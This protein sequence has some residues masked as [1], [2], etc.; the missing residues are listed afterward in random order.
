MPRRPRQRADAARRLP[1]QRAAQAARAAPA[2]PR[3]HPGARQRAGRGRASR[4]TRSRRST[5]PRST[6]TR[7]A[8]RTSL[9]RP[10]GPRRSGSTSSATW[11]RPAGGRSGSPRA[12]ASRSPPARRCRSAP[13]WWCPVHWTDQGMAAVEIYHAPKRGSRR[14]PGRRRAAG[15]PRAGAGRRVRDPGDGRGASPRPASG[16]SWSG[17][18]PGSW[19]W[20][21]AT[22]WSTSAGPA[23]PARWS[24]PTRTRSPPPPS[25]PARYA[26]RIG[27][28]DDDPEGLRG[29]LEDQTLRAD[30]IITTGGTGTGPGDMVRR[31]LS[32][33]DAGRGSVD[34]T[35]VALCP[36]T[37]PRLRHR[38]RRGGA[39][40]LPARRAGR[41]A[42]RLRGAG[43][44][45][46]PAAGRRRAGV[47]AQRAGAPA[48][49]RVARPAGCGSSGPAHVAERR[50]GGYTVQPLAGGPYTL[51]GLAEA[52]GL[53]VLGERVTSAAAGSTVDVLLLDRTAMMLWVHARDGRR[54]GGRTRAARGRTAA[55]TR[56]PGRRSACAN[57]AVAGAVGVRRRPAPGPS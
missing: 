57:Q 23:S 46:D 9:G 18:A 16:T 36:G 48:G 31:V 47:P 2:R 40:G 38:R 11:A 6:A 32:R 1:G 42:D 44:A 39:G 27:I 41:R 34:F 24:T 30:L 15:R 29:L 50:G 35:D 5:R 7:P 13:T 45:G 37:L 33:R 25:R 53:L 12:P 8:A 4:R 43:P 28:C 26:Y 17:P 51:S 54:P 55:A 10:A 14:P 22:S 21:P 19:W 3:P 52:N 49:D 56:G 20:P